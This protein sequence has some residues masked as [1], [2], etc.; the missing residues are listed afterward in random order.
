MSHEYVHSISN[1]EKVGF[2]FN[3]VEQIL[4]IQPFGY[5][6]FPG[7]HSLSDAEPKLLEC[8]SYE[9]IDS[10]VLVDQILTY[11]IFEVVQALIFETQEKHLALLVVSNNEIISEKFYH[12]LLRTKIISRLKLL[13]HVD[14]SEKKQPQVGII[15]IEYRDKIYLTK[16]LFFPQALGESIV[17]LPS[18]AK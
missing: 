6:K 4:S 1:E 15:N 14:P 5:N 12:R 3:K 10:S 16:I 9:D 8:D 18:L 7:T 2:Y 13:T 17:I 11:A